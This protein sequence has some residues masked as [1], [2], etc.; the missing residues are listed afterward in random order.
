MAC[1]GNQTVTRTSRRHRSMRS[2]RHDPELGMTVISPVSSLRS[3]DDGFGLIIYI[4]SA[5]ARGR[6][7]TDEACVLRAM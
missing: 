3:Y 7:L 5:S 2:S 1:S 6:I 4:F